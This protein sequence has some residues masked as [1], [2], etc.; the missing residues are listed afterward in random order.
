MATLDP[1]GKDGHA[2]RARG[3]TKAVMRL[4]QDRLEGEQS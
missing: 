2:G 3:L 1:E 4:L